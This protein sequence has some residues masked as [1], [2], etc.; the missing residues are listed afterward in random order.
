MTTLPRHPASEARHPQREAAAATPAQLWGC[1][2]SHAPRHAQ[3]AERRFP[4][5]PQLLDG[6]ASR[7]AYQLS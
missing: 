7:P 1:D 3:N 6:E 4:A 2:P 5:L